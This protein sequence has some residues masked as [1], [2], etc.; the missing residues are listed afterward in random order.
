MKIFNLKS[1]TVFLIWSL[2]IVYFS[3]LNERKE[4]Q[5]YQLISERDS[6]RHTSDSIHQWVFALDVELS[7]YQ[8]CFE[9]LEEVNPAAAKEFDRYYSL[10]TE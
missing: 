1:L 8:R 9:H 10:E 3:L 7:R 4:K 2:T 5:I 6:I